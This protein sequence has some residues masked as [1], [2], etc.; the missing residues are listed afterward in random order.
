[1]T[2]A[3]SIAAAALGALLLTGSLGAAVAA[4]VRITVNDTPITDIQISQRAKLMQ[5][6]HHPG[7]LTTA[8]TDE[9]INEALETQEARRLGISISDSQVEQ[10]YLNV[11]RNLKVSE[12][13]LTLILNTAG[14]GGDTLKD[15]IRA[16]LA[17]SQVT[18]NMITPKVT[19]SEADLAKE[20][21]TKV[22]AA[23]SFD[24]ILK[25]IIFIGT[26]PRMADANRYRSQFK[27]CDSAVPLSQSFTDVAVTD[28]G[29]RHATQLQLPVATELGSLPVGG[30][31]K[32]MKDPRGVSMLAICEK[33][34]AKDLT[35]ITNQL[36]Q[37]EGNDRLQQ[38]QDKYLADLKAKAKIVRS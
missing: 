36:R 20:A 3:R 13:K 6:E 7:N 31:T 30:I 2:I 14:V 12:D 18:T 1:M 16:T 10:S 19:F 9:L 15:R 33:E 29:R 32:P 26:S 4:G 11:A 27:G 23:N 8:A 37:T 25:Q 22:T 24:Y 34:E 28:M 38:E 5:L 21:A 17:W 35:F